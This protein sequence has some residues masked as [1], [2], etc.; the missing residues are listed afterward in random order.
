MLALLAACADPDGAPAVDTAAD[1][2]VDWS[3]PAVE[4]ELAVED[5]DA[6]L[7]ETF[8]QHVVHPRRVFDWYWGILHDVA[9][10]DD[11]DCPHLPTESETTPGTAVSLWDGE[12]AGAEYEVEGGWIATFYGVDPEVSEVSGASVLFSMRGAHVEGGEEIYAGG[13]LVASWGGGPGGDEFSYALAGTYLD[14]G[15]QGAMGEGISVR[16]DWT[17]TR[18]EGGALQGTFEG[19][20]GGGV[21]GIELT[22]VTI[23]PACGPGAVGTLAVRDPSSGWWEVVLADD[24]SGCG[25]ATF[26]GEERGESCIGLLLTDELAQTFDDAAEAP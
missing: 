8:R 11:A 17:G 22:D 2:V 26:A 21:G 16:L 15:E 4:P 13:T 5:L 23:D 3:A 24:C 14:A 6:A 25:P 20:L 7:S 12:C 1:P 10:D 9:R 18:P 19:A